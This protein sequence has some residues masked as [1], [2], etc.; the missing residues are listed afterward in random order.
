MF[1]ELPSGESELSFARRFRDHAGANHAVIEGLHP[2]F[3]HSGE[4][5]W[6]PEKAVAGM[7]FR[8]EGRRAGRAVIAVYRT[9]PQSVRDVVR[10]SHLPLASISLRFRH[11]VSRAFR[12][13]RPEQ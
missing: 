1:D 9:L 3:E 13:D 4:N 12:F 2:L 11:S 8:L 6:R 10:R 7:F 5:S